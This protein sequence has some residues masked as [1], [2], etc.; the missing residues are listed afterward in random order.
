M[1]VKALLPPLAALALAACSQPH[2]LTPAQ[3]DRTRLARDIYCAPRT[4]SRID[5]R[6]RR[7]ALAVIQA[8]V[9][10]IRAEAICDGLFESIEVR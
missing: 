7:L 8:H 1:V 6:A 4:E 9:P 2:T 3:F 10:G 5:L